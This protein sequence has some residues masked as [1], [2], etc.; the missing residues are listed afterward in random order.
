MANILA[1]TDESYVYALAHING[2]WDWVRDDDNEPVLFIDY[3]H[4]MA[5]CGSNAIIVSS[6][7]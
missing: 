5:C 1:T 4:A 2:R 6:E 3:D 7:G